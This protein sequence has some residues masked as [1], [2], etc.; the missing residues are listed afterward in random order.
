MNEKLF[1]SVDYAIETGNTQLFDF[2]LAKVFSSL[3]RE[4]K[5]YV[6]HKTIKD[7]PDTDFIQHVLD[8]GFELSFKDEDDNTLLHYA[9]YSNNV[10]TIKFFLK[11]GLDVNTENKM[12]INPLQFA[13]LNTSNVDV[14]KEL[15]SA[16]GDI[17]IRN[18][19]GQTLLAIS[20]GYNP[21]PEITQFFIDQG[22]DIEARD[23]D[24]ATPILTAAQYQENPDVIELLINAGADIDAKDNDGDT[25]FHLAAQNESLPVVYYISSAFS[26]YLVDNNGVSC[27]SDALVGAE[28]PEVIKLYIRKMRTE[29]VM[30]ASRN[31]VP[32]ILEALIQEG[33]DVNTANPDGCTAL[34]FAA[35]MNTNPDIIRMLIYYNAVWNSRDENGRTPLHYAAANTDSAIYKWMLEEENFKTFSNVK[36]K[37]GKLPEYYLTHKDEF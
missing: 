15:I 10:E 6:I 1:T 11:R 13:A 21:A 24:G 8:H 5:E 4:E 7:T 34:M 33:Y 30:F 29:H 3:S 12:G 27:L 35:M 25:M 37:K 22:L 14:I 23:D 19:I 26:T 31:E 17:K 2:L 18:S 20:A 9:A 16:G 36:D 28:N 32:E